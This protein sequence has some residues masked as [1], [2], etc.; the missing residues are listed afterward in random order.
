[1]IDQQGFIGGTVTTAPGPFR[2][3]LE[4][5]RNATRTRGFVHSGSTTYAKFNPVTDAANVIGTLEESILDGAAWYM[6]RTVWAAIRSDARFDLRHSV[7]VLRRIAANE[8]ELGQ[9]PAAARSGPQ[10]TW[11]ASRFTRTAGSPRTTVGFADA[12]PRS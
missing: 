1:M 3:H 2:R 10:A 4:R 8:L 9:D 11:A 5:H 6:H 12:T 7:P